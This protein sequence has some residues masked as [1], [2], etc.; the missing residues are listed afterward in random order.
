[1]RPCLTLATAALSF[2]IA[3]TA[4]AAGPAPQAPPPQMVVPHTVTGTLL[5][6]EEDIY[7]VRDE[8]GQEVRLQV[9]PRDTVLDRNIQVGDRIRAEVF[10][11]GRARSVLK[12]PR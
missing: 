5:R 6:I 8:N 3:I 1:M 2:G 11:D 7:V 4:G 9:S 12:A 10:Q